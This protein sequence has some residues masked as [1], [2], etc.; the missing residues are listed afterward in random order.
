M[1]EAIRSIQRQVTGVANKTSSDDRMSSDDE[2]DWPTIETNNSEPFQFDNKP[3][4]EE[5]TEETLKQK[6]DEVGTNPMKLC[7]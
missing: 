3:D 4:L 7:L 1:V 6:H 5:M 2:D